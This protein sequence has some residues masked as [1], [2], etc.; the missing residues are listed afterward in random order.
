MAPLCLIL[1]S[2]AVNCCTGVILSNTTATV[3]GVWE[4]GSRT[5]AS[6]PP[7]VLD[8]DLDKPLPDQMLRHNNQ[9]VLP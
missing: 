1:N 4:P 8:E 5:I 9:L 6:P 2:P 7:V 3:I